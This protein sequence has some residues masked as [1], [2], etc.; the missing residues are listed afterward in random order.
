MSMGFENRNHLIATLE[1]LGGYFDTFFWA[2][3]V[4]IKPH[5]A[6]EAQSKS[7]YLF[8]TAQLSKREFRYE[9]GCECL[10]IFGNADFKLKINNIY[11]IGNNFNSVLLQV[12]QLHHRGHI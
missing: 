11:K 5:F 4:F 7:H 6:D 1:E 8:R 12:S 3:I 9:S 2:G 10:V